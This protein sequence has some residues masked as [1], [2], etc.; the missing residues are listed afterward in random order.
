PVGSYPPNAWGLY[1][2]AGN[3]W[4]WC[5]DY[6]QPGF[7][8]PLYGAARDPKGPAFSLDTHG[9]GEEKRV[10]RGGSFL[11]S[12]TYCMR[13]RAGGRQEGEAKAGQSHPGSRCVRSPGGK[14]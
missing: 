6:Y 9:G 10:L 8:P 7:Q 5:S 3:A 12:D 4:E 13:Y 2:M 11:C 1:D 14:K